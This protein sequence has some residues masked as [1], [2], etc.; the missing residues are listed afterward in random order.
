MEDSWDWYDQ[1]RKIL[2]AA[3]DAGEIDHQKYVNL[4]QAALKKFLATVGRWKNLQED[5]L[6]AKK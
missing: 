3:F 5:L 2:I 6:A 4:N 1:T